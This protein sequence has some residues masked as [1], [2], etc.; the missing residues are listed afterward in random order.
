MAGFS[1]FFTQCGS[2]LQH[3]GLM[4][5][6]KGKDNAQSLFGISSIP[7]DNQIRNLLEPRPAKTIFGTFKTVIEWL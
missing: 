3:Q 5:E 7:Y 2:F 6:N 1:V 4:K